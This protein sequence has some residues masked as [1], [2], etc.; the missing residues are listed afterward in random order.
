MLFLPSFS[1]V[2]LLSFL[3]P[4]DA[5]GAVLWCTVTFLIMISV[6]FTKSFS[7]HTLP[8]VNELH[9]MFQPYSLPYAKQL[10]LND[11]ALGLQAKKYKNVVV[12]MGAGV[13]SSLLPDFRSPKTGMFDQLSRDPSPVFASLPTPYAIFDLKFAYYPI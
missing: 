2:E 4:S 6:V 11:I 10:T 1:F 13:S 8:N 3:D 12:L 5:K 9:H 7:L